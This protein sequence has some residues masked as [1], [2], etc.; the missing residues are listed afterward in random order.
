MQRFSLLRYAI[1]QTL[2][3]SIRLAINSIL[4]VSLPFA[5]VKEVLTHIPFFF[6]FQETEV[7][8][9]E[10]YS[11]NVD[12]IWAQIANLELLSYFNLPPIRWY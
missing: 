8:S 3:I 4:I 6:G 9:H 7:S 1:P 11:N 10:A 5:T 2:S 12:R